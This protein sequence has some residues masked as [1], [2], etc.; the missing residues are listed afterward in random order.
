M[1]RSVGRPAC[2]DPRDRRDMRFPGALSQREMETYVEG[3]AR[4]AGVSLGQYMRQQLGIPE[5]LPV[6]P[7]TRT[8]SAP[9]AL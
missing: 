1:P 2:A 7:S 6:A 5:H 4:L 9:E 8:E 3:P